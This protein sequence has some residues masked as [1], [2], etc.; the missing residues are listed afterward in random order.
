MGLGMWRAIQGGN[1]MNE[2]ADMI[3]TMMR[4][5]GRRAPEGHLKGRLLEQP[6]RIF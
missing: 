1:A 6:A 4:Y 5:S 2:E 3:D